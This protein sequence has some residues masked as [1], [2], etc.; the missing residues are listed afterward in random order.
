M[1][2]GW[3]P[4]ATSGA[5]SALLGQTPASLLWAAP[6]RLDTVGLTGSENEIAGFTLSAIRPSGDPAPRQVTAGA[7]DD[8]GRRIADAVISFGPGETAGTGQMT[9]PFELRNDFAS[10][11][12][13]GE[14]HA[15]AVRVLDENS[16]RRRV[17]LLSQSEADQAQ[18][19]LSP[20]YYIRRAW[21][22][23]PI[24]SSHQAPTSPKPIPQLLEQKPAMIVMADVGTIPETARARLIDWLKNGGCPWSASPDRASP[25]PATTRNCFRFACALASARWAAHCRGPRRGRHRISQDRPLRRSCSPAEVTVTRQVLAEPTSTLSSGP[26]PISPTE[27]RWSPAHQRQGHGGALPR[28]ARS[29]LVD[30]ADLGQ[31]CRNAAPH[32]AT[33]ANQGAAPRMPKAQSRLRPTA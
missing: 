21:N 15:A 22:R 5:F 20:L 30:P 2:T 8:K 16:K 3:P 14:Q 6:E 9:V 31:L 13:D 33:V 7:F 24:W 17:G 23:S 19:L 25:R 28:H 10:I 26:G 1:P 11:A 18:P 29:D 27:R 12:I 32:C 4:K